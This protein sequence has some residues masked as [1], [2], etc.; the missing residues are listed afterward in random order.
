MEPEPVAPQDAAEPL[1]D[2]EA[3]ASGYTGHARVARLLFIATKTAGS[4]TELEALRLA[5]DQLRKGENTAQY[6]EVMELI[7]GR[8]GPQYTLDRVW[9]EAVDRRAATVQE[10]L[11]ADLSGYKNNMIKESIRMGH[12]EL[13]DFH[14]ARGA[15]QSA[16]KCYVR[17]RDYCTSPRQVTDMCLAVIR[18][19]VENSAFVHVNN[20]VSKAEQTPDAVR[21][22]VVAAKLKCSGALAALEAKKYKTAAK[23]FTEVSVELGNGYADVVAAAD[24]AL[25]GGL[26]ALATMERPELRSAVVDN[27][28][29]REYLDAHPEMREVVYEFYGSRYAACLARL[30][31]LLPLLRM[32]L[33]LAPHVGL[34]YLQVRSKA[35]IQYT[36]PFVSVDLR[37]MAAAFSADVGALERELAELVAARQVQARI[38]SHAKVLYAR[39]ADPRSATFANALRIGEEY[40]RDT[41]ALLLRTQLIQ[42]DLVQRAPGGRGPRAPS[43]P[44]NRDSLGPMAA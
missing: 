16:F 3:Y 23:R 27:V 31:R 4:P 22:K 10:R 8:L 7:D 12:H 34:L 28:A 18:C 11:E 30:Q 5:A 41:R 39:L 33:H 13:A 25:Y 24:V 20:Y 19:A 37:T 38:D 9:V 32:D 42:H 40:L 14:Y 26:C 15:V 29:F 6:A 1:L 43:L 2:L 21:D 36:A 17:S 44:H 35:L